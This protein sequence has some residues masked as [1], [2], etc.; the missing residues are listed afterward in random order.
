MSLRV[1]SISSFRYKIHFKIIVYFLEDYN[2]KSWN[3][4]V[5]LIRL[6]DFYLIYIWI[7]FCIST[8]HEYRV[9]DI[10]FSNFGN[11]TYHYPS[12]APWHHYTFNS[13]ETSETS[14]CSECYHKLSRLIETM[15]VMLQICWC[16][17]NY[18]VLTGL[19]AYIRAF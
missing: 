18:F 19:S 1:C 8:T 4:V 13:D 11:T 2:K 5:R 16:W 10:P 6:C 17:I 14:A 15:I 12:W 3:F 9:H 7:S